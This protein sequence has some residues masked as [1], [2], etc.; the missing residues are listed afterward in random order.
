MDERKAPK[1]NRSRDYDLEKGNYI[2]TAPNDHPPP[3]LLYLSVSLPFRPLHV[4]INW[5]T[6]FAF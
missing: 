2:S 1:I 4:V 3:P 6:V 5:L